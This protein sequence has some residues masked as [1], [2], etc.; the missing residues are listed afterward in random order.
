MLQIRSGGRHIRRVGFDDG[1]CNCR[2]SGRSIDAVI[3]ATPCSHF[4]KSHLTFSGFRIQPAHAYFGPLVYQ[5]F[6]PEDPFWP[7]FCPSM[8]ALQHDFSASSV[9]SFPPM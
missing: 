1:G 8:F 9:V 4:S 7:S 2:N 3:A 6:P 5:N